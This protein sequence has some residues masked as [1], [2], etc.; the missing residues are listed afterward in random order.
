M[1]QDQNLVCIHQ[2]L[3]R[4]LHV[5]IFGHGMIPSFLTECGPAPGEAH[6]HRNFSS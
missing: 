2:A 5:E 1:A 6:T 4:L 3:R